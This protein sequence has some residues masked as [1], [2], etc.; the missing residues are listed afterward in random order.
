MFPMFCK[1][2]SSTAAKRLGAVSERENPQVIGR[3][4]RHLA[5]GV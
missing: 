2:K 3:W 4:W 5:G 1:L